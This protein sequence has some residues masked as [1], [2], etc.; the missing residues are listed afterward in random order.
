MKSTL[1]FL[2]VFLS[3]NLFGQNVN[4]PDT[5]FKNYLVNNIAINTNSDSEIQVSEANAFAG[6]IDCSSQN[7][8]DL[9]GIEAFTVLTEL[10]C[11][12]NQLASLD[13]SSN[14]ALTFLHCQG[15]QLISLDLSSNIVLET[16]YCGL[17]Q[18]AYLDL[19]NS[20][21]LTFLDCFGNQLTSLDVY[22]NTALGMM[23]CGANQLTSLN[24]SNNTYLSVLNCDNNLLECLNV[25]NGNNQYFINLYASGNP[26]LTCIEVDDV[27][28]STNNW[29]NID[30]QT[31]F[32]T[33]CNNNGCSCT[34]TSSTDTQS[35]CDSYTWV[36]GNTY[37]TSNNS[38]TY[39]TSNSAGCDSTITLNLTISPT[40]DNSITQ[41]G[42]SLTATQTGATYQWIDCD[43]FF[44]P[45]IGEVNQTFFPSLSGYYAVE[46]TIGDCSST[47]ECRLVEFTG[48]DEIESLISVHPNPTKDEV[49]L[50]IGTELLGTGFVVT[51]NAGRIILTDTFKSTKQTVN[52]SG[53]NNGVYFITTDKESP[54]KIIKQ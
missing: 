47:S 9:T 30:P 54:V 19:P 6:A 14:N 12:N 27:N 3:A 43:N 18:L 32:S 39:T 2:S 34:P 45:V 25:K 13:V 52:L 50:S 20:S 28:Y 42:G 33:D 40:P 53:F 17:N 11:F 49:T 4:I 36:D 41:N 37:I 8:L 15:N 16:I 51:D 44:V 29:T 48:I 46:V 21:T 10:K 24:L 38:A 5:N 7:I 26:N 35:A 22:Q 23:G 1:L 31:S